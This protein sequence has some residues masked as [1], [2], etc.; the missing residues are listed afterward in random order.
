LFELDKELQAIAADKY[1]PSEELRLKTRSMVSRAAQKRSKAR[2]SARKLTRLYP[3]VAA[4]LA[5]IL[6]VSVFSAAPAQA[7]GYYTIDINPSISIAVD[8]NDNVLSVSAKNSEAE[9]LLAGLELAGMRFEDALKVIIQAAAQEGYLKDQG[10]LLVAHFGNDEGISQQELELIVSDQLPESGV[11]VLALHGGK[12]DFDNAESAGKK[13]GIELL[14]RGAREAG[15]EDE[16]IGVVIGKMSGK[17]GN[18]GGNS[19]NNNNNDDGNEQSSDN[20]GNNSNNGN[21]GSN[22][23]NGNG[24]QDNESDSEDKNKDA[25]ID[26]DKDTKDKDNKGNDKDVKDKGK[27]DKDKNK[28]DEN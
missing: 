14:L 25:D 13:A 8:D 15:I 19:G 11:S 21:N 23:N 28:Q 12:D 20:Q 3:A 9:G 18:A 22:D 10:R 26:K 7:A 4:A 24:G 5:I 17:Q 16:D 2:P 1:N 6:F 27:S